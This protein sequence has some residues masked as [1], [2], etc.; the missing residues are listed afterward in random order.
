MHTLTNN[1]NTNGYA[2]TLQSRFSLSNEELETGQVYCARLNDMT[3]VYE[4]L[5]NDNKVTG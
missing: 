4:D 5:S 3:V 2:L 1:T